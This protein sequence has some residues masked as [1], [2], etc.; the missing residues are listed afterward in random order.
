MPVSP[1]QSTAHSLK[2][3]TCTCIITL[4]PMSYYKVQ[5]E[6]MLSS[7]KHHGE[8]QSKMR[9]QPKKKKSQF[10]QVKSSY[11]DKND[12]ERIKKELVKGYSSTE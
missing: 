1:S 7:L 2:I 9:R 3:H 10:T 5:K 12:K 8:L 4:G 6:Q 11:P